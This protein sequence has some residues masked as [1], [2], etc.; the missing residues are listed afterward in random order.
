MKCCTLC[1]QML[2]LEAF[3]WKDQGKGQRRSWC[4]ECVNG[5][6]RERKRAK[7]RAAGVK[8][9]ELLMVGLDAKRC[10]TCREVKALREFH[11]CAEKKGGYQSACIACR[12]VVTEKWRKA[13]AQLISQ[14]GARYYAEHKDKVNAASKEHRRTH[15]Q[16]YVAYKRERIQALRDSYVRGLIS[17]VTGLPYARIPQE[18]VEAKRTHIKLTRFLKEHMR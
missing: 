2:P 7:R 5:D 12:K 9:R 13:N 1:A 4:R 15:A 18:M 14:R 10:S 17:E 6:A 3:A 11:L 16:W 8:P